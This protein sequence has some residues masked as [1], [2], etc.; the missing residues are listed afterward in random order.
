[1]GY[2][3]N[4]VKEP[5]NL[6]FENREEKRF[7]TPEEDLSQHWDDQEFDCDI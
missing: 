1:M 7:F 3:L 6:E 2:S 4:S 5:G